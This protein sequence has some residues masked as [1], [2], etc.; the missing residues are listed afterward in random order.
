MK[1]TVVIVGGGLGGLFAGAML[2]KEGIGVTVIEKN[3]TIG[4]GLQTFERFGE[5]FDTGMHVLGG[6]RKGGSVWRI[7]EYLGIADKLRLMDV[8]DTCSD[9]IYFAE[10]GSSYEVGSGEEGFVK[11][12]AA[13]FPEEEANIRQ[14]VEAIV[15]MAGKVDLFNLRPSSAQLSMMPTS[16]G[17]L[18]PADEYIAQ[19]VKDARLRMLLAYKSPHYG[20]V[21]GKTPA[22]IHAIVSTLYIKGS[23]RFVGGSGQMATL[24]AGVIR[25][26]GGEVVAG[27]GVSH[28]E[29]EDKTVREVRTESGNVYRADYY[30][31]AIHP[32][33][34]F[35]LLSDKALP[36][37]YR[38]RLN[39][40]PNSISAFSLYIK[41]K[42]GAFPFMNYS[43]YYLAK[44]ADVWGFSGAGEWLR[45]FIM[46]TPPVE[47]QGTYSDTVVVVAPMAF[48]NV[49][50]WEYTTVGRRGE[51][52][53][54]WK[55]ARVEELLGHIEE[56]HPRFREKVEAV[57]ASSPLTIRDYYGVKEGSMCGFSKDCNDMMQ[58]QVPVVTKVKNLLLT[59]QN[60]NLHGIC[61]VPL[62]AIN[63]SEVILGQNYIINKI[64]ECTES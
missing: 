20:G 62:T 60:S 36:K 19:F 64:N 45:G 17:F 15:G 30:I 47:G 39:S 5:E 3:R 6:M 53:L 10:D 63:T 25:E 16:D 58:S 54:A 31:S 7:C 41:M 23:T 14:Y 49:R 4:G 21:G 13:Y 26:N 34:M 24:L 8:S 42:A 2:A 40:I 28:I 51:E 29:V 9:K 11:T 12:L 1:R 52:Y 35:G 61:G 18:K 33:T 57:E 43:E 55:R 59:G 27:D 22:Y 48:E 44:G 32:C 37:S 50:Q 56:I 38:D 46:M